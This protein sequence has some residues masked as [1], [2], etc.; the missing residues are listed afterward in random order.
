[1]I[2]PVRPVRLIVS[3]PSLL[4]AAHSPATAPDAVFVFAAMIASRNVHRPSALFAASEVLLTVIVLPAAPAVSS[5]KNGWL[6]SNKAI[7][8]EAVQNETEK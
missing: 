7:A 4:P 1:M 8:S 3:V 5:P 2:V 6:E